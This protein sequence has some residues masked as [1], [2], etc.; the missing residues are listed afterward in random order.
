MSKWAAQI[1]FINGIGSTALKILLTMWVSLTSCEISFRKIKLI[2]LYL[3]S[4][5]SEGRLTNFAVLPVH[6]K[7][8]HSV[9]MKL[10]QILHTLGQENF[11]F[12]FLVSVI[13]DHSF[14]TQQKTPINDCNFLFRISLRE[15]HFNNRLWQVC[16]QNFSW[17]WGDW[18]WPWGY[19]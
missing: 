15:D 6:D 16:T 19:I 1:H 2:Q 7:A 10:L 5:T 9:S 13:Y 17:G 8:G 4:V 3:K 18:G 14:G 12:N 11:S